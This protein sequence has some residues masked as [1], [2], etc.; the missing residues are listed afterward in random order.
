MQSTAFYFYDIID[1]VEFVVLISVID[2]VLK[3]NSLNLTL[4]VTLF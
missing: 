4:L 1:K 2:N 3:Y